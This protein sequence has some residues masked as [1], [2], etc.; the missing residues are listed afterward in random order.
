MALAVKQRCVGTPE[1]VGVRV[2]RIAAEVH[3]HFVLVGRAG[4]RTESTAVAAFIA[5][6][7]YVDY[8][9]RLL[10]AAEAQSAYVGGLT[11]VERFLNGP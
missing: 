1:T 11:I 2:E 3:A 9:G 7:A 8:L 5:E 10:N 6:V 4:R